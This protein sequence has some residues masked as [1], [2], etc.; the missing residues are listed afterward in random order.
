[1]EQR[2]RLEAEGVRF[3]GRRVRMAEYEFKFPKTRP[4][5]RSRK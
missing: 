3:S 2:F 5:K 1:M 4:R